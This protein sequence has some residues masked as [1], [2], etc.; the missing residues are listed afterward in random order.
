MK[1]DKAYVALMIK[2]KEMRG[3]NGKE[4]MKYLDAAIELRERGSVS[5]D[6][7]IGGAYY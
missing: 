3:E 2:Y 7:F 6:A 4:A 5:E 1:D